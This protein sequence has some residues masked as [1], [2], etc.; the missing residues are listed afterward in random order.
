MPMRTGMFTGLSPLT[1]PD[2]GA[3]FSR[4]DARPSTPAHR[5]AP[6]RAA[7]ERPVWRLIGRKLGAVSQLEHRKPRDECLCFLDGA[8]IPGGG[9]GESRP[10]PCTA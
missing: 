6:L 9:M 5:I 4:W 2:A 10:A 3:S 8:E 1:W 7:A